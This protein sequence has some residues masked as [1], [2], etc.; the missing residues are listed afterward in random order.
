M[1]LPAG[2]EGDDLLPSD[3]RHSQPGGRAVPAVAGFRGGS[4]GGRR[5]QGGPER[6]RG[7]TPRPAAVA[8]L[9]TRPLRTG[10]P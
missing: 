7:R 10:L 6:H 5:P 1:P 2:A 9:A 8:R 4:Q 3:P